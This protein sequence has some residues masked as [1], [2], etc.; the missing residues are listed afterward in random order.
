M[1]KS[2]GKPIQKEKFKFLKVFLE[3]S[4]PS[5]QLKEEGEVL[6]LTGKNINNGELTKRG[7]DKYLDFSDE[8]FKKYDKS[9]LNPGDII[10]ATFMDAQKIYQ[11]KETDP[12]SFSSN[13]QIILR[14]KEND[15]LSK[16]FKIEEFYKQF[17]R[18]CK[19]V[20]TGI[21]PMLSLEQ[22]LEIEIFQLSD[23]E[24]KKK[25]EEEN[26]SLIQKDNLLNILKIMFSQQTNKFYKKS[27]WM[28]IMK[29]L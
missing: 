12:P 6:Y 22:F 4:I 28:I 20:S 10:A 18:D 7:G 14:T 11:F 9:I 21:I 16:Y 27:N 17:E 26:I 2:K 13:N 15:Y 24:L 8:Y 3:Y 29:I 23:T 5:N 19:K 25:F 1:E